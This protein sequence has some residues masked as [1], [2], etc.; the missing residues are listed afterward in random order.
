MPKFDDYHRTVIG[1][2]GTTLSVALSLVTR[3][4]EFQ[5]SDRDYDW[6]GRGIYFWEYAPMQALNFAQIRQNQLKKKKNKTE[7]ETY[8]STEPLA[9]VACMIRSGICLDLTEPDNV[10]YVR[11]KFNDYKKAMEKVGEKLP[12]NTRKY[13]K[14]D[15]A[16]F[17]Y[18]YK[19]IEELMPNQSIETSRGIYVSTDG[20]KR[21]WE[22]SWVSQDTHIQLCVRNRKNILRAWLHHPTKLEADDV[23]KTIEISR[24]HFSAADS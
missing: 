7:K 15:C 3:I 13:R 12:V 9:V 5:A 18:A 1:Y 21:I 14:L 17:E 20:T 11:E 19:M 8:R 23:R 24:V 10:A 22:G 2:H 16:V 4:A 6:L